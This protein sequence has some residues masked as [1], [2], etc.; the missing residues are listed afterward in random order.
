MNKK[1]EVKAKLAKIKDDFTSL[2]EAIKQN[3][4]SLAWMLER[5]QA[6]LR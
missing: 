2:R 6:H 4:S 5:L 1:L 3:F